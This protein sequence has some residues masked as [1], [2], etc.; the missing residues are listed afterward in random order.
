MTHDGWQYLRT[1]ILDEDFLVP[2]T[3]HCCE[4]LITKPNLSRDAIAGF[5]TAQEWLQ[6]MVKLII[7]NTCHNL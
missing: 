2:V 4:C 3:T 5:T 6:S 7:Y 1:L